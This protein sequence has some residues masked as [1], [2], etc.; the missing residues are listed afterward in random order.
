MNSNDAELLEH[1]TRVRD[2][3][4]NVLAEVAILE[5]PH[6]AEPKVRWVVAERFPQ[7]AGASV[8]EKTREATLKD[9]RYF[10]RCIECGQRRVKGHLWT[11][12]IC[13]TCASENHGVVF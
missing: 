12:D 1:F 8:V 5:W 6:P 2:D 10:G 11:R 13:M 3:G 9:R 7:S 4:K